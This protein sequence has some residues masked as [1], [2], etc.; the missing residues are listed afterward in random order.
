MA[1]VSLAR[2]NNFSSRAFFELGAEFKTHVRGLSAVAPQGAWAIT[3]RI[4]LGC[5]VS[6]IRPVWLDVRGGHGCRRRQTT[7]K[8]ESRRN[9]GLHIN[10]RRRRTT[11]AQK[12]LRLAP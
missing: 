8:Q 7:D 10:R 12:L 1:R 4:F 6:P 3:F 2:N 11:N 9:G 5:P